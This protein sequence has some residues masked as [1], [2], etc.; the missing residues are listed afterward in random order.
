MLSKYAKKADSMLDQQECDDLL[1]TEP[2]FKDNPQSIKAKIC[3]LFAKQSFISFEQLT[4]FIIHL[5]G[6]EALLIFNKTQIKGKSTL[7]E[8][9]VSTIL[10]EAFGKL[11]PKR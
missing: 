10:C 5:K 7:N 2:L 8:H 6:E 9:E 11:W 1:N 4:S 3:R